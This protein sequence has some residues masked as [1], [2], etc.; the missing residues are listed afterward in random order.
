MTRFRYIGEDTDGTRQEGELLAASDESARKQLVDQGLQIVELTPVGDDDKTP[1]PRLS[2]KESEDVVVAIAELSNSEL[3]LVEGLRAAADE[4]ASSRVAKA[5]RQIAGDV[6]Q[7]FALESVMSERG[8][9]LP[10]HVRGLV[11]AAARTQRIGL[12]L[13]DLVE[14]HRAIA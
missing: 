8:K 13:D 12:A 6:E 14:H 10:P 5:L 2:P 3:P 4:A 11:A 9:F 1:A 7:G